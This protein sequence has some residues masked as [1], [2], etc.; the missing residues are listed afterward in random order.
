MDNAMYI[1]L[2][3]VVFVVIFFI[4]K[5]NKDDVTYDPSD[6]GE[7]TED[8]DTA[9]DASLDLKGSLVHPTF[10]M[11]W[12]NSETSA[13]A[14]GSKNRLDG[15][16]A[17]TNHIHALLKS[18]GSIKNTL[19]QNLTVPSADVFDMAAATSRAYTDAI[20]RLASLGKSIKGTKVLIIYESGHGGQVRNAG[21]ND[22]DKLAETRVFYDKM[23]ND[24]NTRTFIANT[25]GSDWKVL[26]VVD[27]CHSG[28]MSRIITN[29]HEF[30][31][32]VVAKG[33]GLQPT[34]LLT[35]VPSVSNENPA[36]IK[37]QT[38][39][40]E[41]TSAM[42]YGAV[43]GGLFTSKWIE[44]IKKSGGNISYSDANKYAAQKCGATQKPELA[45]SLNQ[46]HSAWSDS[47]KIF[48]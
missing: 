8:S 27:R 7:S 6:I 40:S 2:G 48:N 25:L 43:I 13:S 18:Y 37:F 29:S 44:G 21:D 3:L 46:N 47:T 17:D 14:Y 1:I 4:V 31:P 10:A 24:D 9:S 45:A 12:G 38:A 16:A 28:G 30:N 26:N 39:A 15:V 22:N 19:G 33:I 36:L 35:A 5:P 41:G 20:K 42:D 23:V 32:S 11:I 34:K